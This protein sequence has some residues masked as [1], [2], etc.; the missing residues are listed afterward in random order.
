MVNLLVSK[1]RYPAGSDIR[2]NPNYNLILSYLRSSR[3]LEAEINRQA[4]GHCGIIV[5]TRL[6]MKAAAAARAKKNRLR[7]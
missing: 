3:E 5:R 7:G 1:I 2:P 4:R 6:R